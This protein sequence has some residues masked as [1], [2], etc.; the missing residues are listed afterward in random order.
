MR[1]CVRARA[2]RVY[3]AHFAQHCLPGSRACR[4][5]PGHTP[6]RISW[7]Y[8]FC[9]PSPL[10]A[11][12]PLRIT[13]LWMFVQSLCVD[14]PRSSPSARRL[15]VWRPGRGA[16]GL[17]PP[18]PRRR[19]LSSGC[20]YSLPGG[21]WCLSRALSAVFLVSLCKSRIN[22][23]YGKLVYI[24]KRRVKFHFLNGTWLWRP[25]VARGGC[26]A[27]SRERAVPGLRAPAALW[28]LPAPCPCRGVDPGPWRCAPGR[29][30]G[31]ETPS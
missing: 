13:L 21:K 12:W 14:A 6:F 1:V 16:R 24:N 27:P 9:L 2:R 30:S 18:R 10:M 4:S 22:E 20:N 7:M 17:L 29:S 8:H 23:N 31:Q 15:R 28:S 19:L 3:L 26:C 25:G 5:L 11:V